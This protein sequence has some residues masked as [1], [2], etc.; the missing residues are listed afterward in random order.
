MLLCGVRVP[1]R[2]AMVVFLL[3]YLQISHTLYMYV[4]LLKL[5]VLREHIAL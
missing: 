1:L 5:P 4:T 2:S 3:K